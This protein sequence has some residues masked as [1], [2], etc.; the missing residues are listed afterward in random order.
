MASKQQHVEECLDGIRRCLLE[1]ALVPFLGAGIS[2]ACRPP[3]SRCDTGK[4]PQ[5]EVCGATHR[6]I[7]DEAG[8]GTGQSFEPT[9]SSLIRSLAHWLRRR[10]ESSPDTAKRAGELLGVRDLHCLNEREFVERLSSTASLDRLAEVCTWLSDP[11]TVC[12]ALR[13]E[14]FTTLV[15]RAAHRY[16]AYLVR[17]GLIDEIVT[18]NWDTCIE[19]ALT[20]SF[21]PRLAARLDRH[22]GGDDAPFHVIREVDEHRRWGA[23][24][25]RGRRRP[26]LRLY[27][28]NGCA[29][30]YASDG[31]AEAERIALTERQLQGFR[32]NHWAED[33]F[34]DRAR[35][36]RLLFS[37]FGSDEP[38][39]R[40]AVL[41]LAPELSAA[42]RHGSRR[43][44]FV[45]VYEESPTFCQYQLLRAYYRDPG[46]LGA[47]DLRVGL[48]QVVTAVHAE[49]FP[50]PG[51]ASVQC[52]TSPK[53]CRRP[54][55]GLD[56]DRFWF[57]VYLAAVYG[58]VERYCEQP[59]PFHAW[60]AQ[61]DAAPAREATRL[62]RWLYPAPGRGKAI[63][64]LEGTFGR[65]PA[66]FR[67]TAPETTPC[68][69]PYIGC[70]GVGAGPMRLWAWLAAIQGRRIHAPG[71]PCWRHD[72]YLPM[73]DASLLVLSTLYVLMTL[74]PDLSDDEIEKESRVWRDPA[75]VGLDVQIGDL[76]QS[77]DE[78]GK[79]RPG[80]REDTTDVGLT[81]RIGDGSGSGSDPGAFV[82][83][84]VEHGAPNP[85]RF[86]SHRIGNLRTRIRYRL[87]VTN[88]FRSRPA[89]LAV[90][91]RP[92]RVAVRIG[93]WERKRGRPEES[94]PELRVG[95]FVQIPAEAAAF[96]RAT[97][98]D[99]DGLPRKTGAARATV[100]AVR[101][102]AA[103]L[104]PGTRAQLTLRAAYG[105]AGTS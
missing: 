9:T 14:C 86:P 16:I 33:L 71:S 61:C 73:R 2:Y 38:Q 54:R 44:P 100:Q 10:C 104:V 95:R 41:A 35:S 99:R 96:A 32:D 105:G 7:C 24:R 5:R 8:R 67:P 19:R 30:A 28:I 21:G 12:T 40:H 17:E 63:A 77:Q 25:R 31:A 101:R 15:P 23:L 103:G 51:L 34:R 55:S 83:T 56:A 97:T 70:D 85:S 89:R 76:D 37:G 4:S 87:A 82:V 11:R 84:I 98:A 6:D 74:V 53:P 29:A 80:D 102:A 58:L 36:H 50:D 64:C 69:W 57:G 65:L 90:T 78:F 66:L 47:S 27:K 62:R 42:S 79:K 94:V 92:A 91:S 39:I 43:A 72:W 20:C 60:L 48:K 59:F 93:R 49:H 22:G 18:T 81:G 45:H 68:C 13:I 26:V 88:R 3:L 75:D 52:S 46:A 1:G